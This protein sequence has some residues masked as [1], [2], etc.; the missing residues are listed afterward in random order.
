MTK[1]WLAV[2]AE[3]FAALCLIF[4]LNASAQDRLPI[5]TSVAYQD[6]FV[7]VHTPKIRHFKGVQPIGAEVN[8]QYQTTGKKFWHQLYH[9][10]RLGISLLGLDYRQPILGKSVAASIYISKLVYDHPQAK[11]RVRLGTGLA[12]FSNYFDRRTNAT[13]NVVSAPLNAVIQTRVEYDRKISQ[14]LSVVTA[15]GIN[16]YSNGGNAKPNLG[17]NIGTLS[18]G[19][20]YYSHRDF[21]PITQDIPPIQKSFRSR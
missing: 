17:I 2:R 14:K 8:L 11:I 16:H 18:V 7:M 4:N 9:Y 20:D 5:I 3:Y 19:L 12:Y 15:V 10:P 6:G 1:G 13:N 21:V